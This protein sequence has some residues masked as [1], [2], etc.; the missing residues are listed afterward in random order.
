MKIF[1]GRTHERGNVSGL[2]LSDIMFPHL[3]PF[4]LD[5]LSLSLLYS[6]F[7]LS[8]IYSLLYTFLLN[9]FSQHRLKCKVVPQVLE[10]LFA[11]LRHCTIH[12]IFLFCL[13]RYAFIKGCPHREGSTFL[14][15]ITISLNLVTLY[16][17]LNVMLY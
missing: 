16:A 7:S 14:N 17:I 5:H 15:V 1:T 2:K 4:S 12:L 3:L 10:F 6:L 11:S 13:C 9:L 8:L